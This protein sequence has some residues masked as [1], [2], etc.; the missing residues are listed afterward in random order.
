MYECNV[1]HIYQK[2]QFND[3]Y[4]FELTITFFARYNNLVQSSM[5]HVW[6]CDLKIIDMKHQYLIVKICLNRRS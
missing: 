1:N 5:S 4:M 6:M 2:S 3:G